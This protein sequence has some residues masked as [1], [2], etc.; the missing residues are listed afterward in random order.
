MGLNRSPKQGW[1]VFSIQKG[2]YFF[3]EVP[4]FFLFSSCPSQNVFSPA[5]PQWETLNLPVFLSMVL[6]YLASW[7]QSDS[8]NIDNS[9]LLLNS[10]SALKSKRTLSPFSV[11][12]ANCI[13]SSGEWLLKDIVLALLDFW[14]ASLTIAFL[15]C[16][17]LMN[18]QPRLCFT[19]D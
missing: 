5:L 17:P 10:G 13:F 7:C 15:K 16:I 2:G 1:Q 9:S 14:P 18:C 19:V 12:N 4:F 8:L 11:G 6:Y 3:W